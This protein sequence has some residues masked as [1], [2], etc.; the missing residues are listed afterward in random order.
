MPP[1]GILKML[2]PELRKELDRRLVDGNF[3]GYREL[4][5]WLATRGCVISPQAV[6]KYGFKMEQHLAR[7][8]LITQQAQAVA[9]AAPDD[10][11]KVTEGMLRLVQSQLFKV[12]VDLTPAS[13]K[14]M[15]LGAM[16]ASVAQMGRATV[17]HRKWV[18]EWR[19][20]LRERAARA[21]A[22]LVSAVTAAGGGLT[23]ET[24]EAIRKS[25]LEI[26]Q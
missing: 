14:K 10:D 24:T 22:K 20:G 18:E 13:A 21:E 5:A 25:L 17:M 9:E 4:T 12:L 8:K 16:A 15:N 11:C 6:Q 2:P 7:V 19:V 26:T 3:S 23:A 1:R